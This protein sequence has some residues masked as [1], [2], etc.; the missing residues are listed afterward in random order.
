MYCS[1]DLALGEA[2]SALNPFA[3]DRDL[4]AP[5]PV[6]AAEWGGNLTPET[7]EDVYRAVVSPGGLASLPVVRE[8]LLP[9]RKMLPESRAS[10]CTSMGCCCVNISAVYCCWQSR[11]DVTE[12]HV[13][14]FHGAVVSR[15]EETSARF[16][17]LQHRLRLTVRWKT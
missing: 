1:S 17:S 14:L 11:A 7:W 9:F 2:G 4:G 3:L 12:R 8:Y 10:W 16:L 6:A 13:W 5:P 15:R